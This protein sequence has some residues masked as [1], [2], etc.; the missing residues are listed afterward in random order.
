MLSFAPKWTYDELE[1]Q[2]VITDYQLIPAEGWA[3][4]QKTEYLRVLQ[5]DNCTAGD[6][7]RWKPPQNGY[8]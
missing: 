4:E 5:T 1:R 6:R 2:G 7:E 3:V 8:Q